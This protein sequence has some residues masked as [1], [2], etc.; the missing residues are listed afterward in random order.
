[1]SEKISVRGSRLFSGVV[2]FGAGLVLGIAT[3]GWAAEPATSEEMQVERLAIVDERGEE[4]IIIGPTEEV[5]A[6]AYG[7]LIKAP[8]SKSGK[9]YWHIGYVGDRPE[10]ALYNVWDDGKSDVLRVGRD[11]SAYGLF[12]RS[13]RGN[14]MKL[15]VEDGVGASLVLRGAS[16]TLAEL[17]APEGKDE[18][19]LRVRVGEKEKFLGYAGQSPVPAKGANE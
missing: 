5:G 16:D 1:M 12:S 9:E 4:K 8:D 13:Q 17:S 15:A 10:V 11:G 3:S 14:E 18:I 19:G 7:I 2:L 6:D